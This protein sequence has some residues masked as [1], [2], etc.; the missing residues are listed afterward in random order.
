MSRR[1]LVAVAATAAAVGV[2]SFGGYRITKRRQQR[3]AQPIGPN[4]PGVA[5]GG[6]RRKARRDRDPPADELFDMPSD[7]TH[8]SVPTPDG[9]SLHV[10]ERGDG[11]PLMLLHGITLSAEVWAPQLNQLAD[12]YRVIA[13]DLR[14]HGQSTAGRDGYG[15][16][17][18]ATDVAT[19]LE[20]LDLDDAVL[21]GH[22]MG[23]M[24]VM[25]FCDDHAD[26]LSRR[27]A[28][29]VFVAT[30]AHA[31]VP[32]LL[33]GMARQLGAADRPDS[34]PGA[35]CPSRPG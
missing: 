33:A 34:T 1:R 35:S 17:R 13:V 5:R 29:V 30:R 14:G 18:L 6:G 2:A 28:G 32:P 20:A 16:P 12:R 27:V 4:G 3:A 7:V 24:T 10:M 22:S 19:V 21:V 9:G 25:Q 15:I 26:V 8:R 11:R 23:G 31:V